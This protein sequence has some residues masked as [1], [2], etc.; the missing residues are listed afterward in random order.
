MHHQYK[1]VF[2]SLSKFKKIAA[3]V[4]FIFAAQLAVV[5]AQPS[6][7]GGCVESAKKSIITAGVVAA[8]LVL[9]DIYFTGGVITALALAHTGAATVGGAV[10]ALAG[11][12][13]AGAAVT[14]CAESWIFEKSS[15]S[16]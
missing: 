8:S 7:A 15:P 12:G 14:G 16:R 3:C 2:M 9:A 6:Y 10:V 5:P 11:K 13:A 1:E 4:V